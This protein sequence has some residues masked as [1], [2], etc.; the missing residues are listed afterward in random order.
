M[1]SDQ[2]KDGREKDGSVRKSIIHVM[3]W[4]IKVESNVEINNNFL[5]CLFLSIGYDPNGI[6]KVSGFDCMSAFI[7]AKAGS[8]WHRMAWFGFACHGLARMAARPGMA[9]QRHAWLQLYL[10]LKLS[11]FQCVYNVC[12]SIFLALNYRVHAFNALQ[13]MNITLTFFL[14]CFAKL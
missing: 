1:F 13:S 4:P 2:M 3:C 5:F 11:K 9:V 7:G 14:L 10:S 8:E 12:L 6:S